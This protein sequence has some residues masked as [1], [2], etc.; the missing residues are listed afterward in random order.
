MRSKALLQIIFGGHANQT[1]ARAEANRQS[2]RYPAKPAPLLPGG[3]DE[4]PGDSDSINLM[5]LRD[6]CA[7]LKLRMLVGKKKLGWYF[8]ERL[9][10]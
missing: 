10:H 6:W 1:R 8:R 4:S 5:W 3:F 9:R 7:P 2:L